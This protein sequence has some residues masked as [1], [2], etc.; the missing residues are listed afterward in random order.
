MPVLDTLRVV[1]EGGLLHRDISPHNIYITKTKQVKL[2]DFGAAR[3]AL[4][5]GAR[6]CR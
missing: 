6:A 4:G 3:H 5:D 2:L 1:H